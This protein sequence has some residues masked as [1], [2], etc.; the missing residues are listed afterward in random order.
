MG[1]RSPLLKTA[2]S[3]LHVS[4]TDDKVPS[5]YNGGLSLPQFHPPLPLPSF[6]PVL[7][8]D[9]NKVPA[10]SSCPVT[11]TLVILRPDDIQHLYKAF[12]SPTHPQ[13]FFFP[14]NKLNSSPKTTS[15]NKHQPKCP[16][17]TTPPRTPASTTATSSA[18]VSRTATATSSTPSAT[19]TTASATTTAVSTGV[20][21]A[22]LIPPRASASSSRATSPSSAP[23]SST[24]RARPS[25]PT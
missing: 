25:T 21:A 12:P 6:L 15:T 11:P 20:A 8:L 19:S 7:Q 5:E 24:L 3:H 14:L 2:I 22:S 1:T 4:A 16:T 23:A 10:T 17:S 13:L 9:V 18:P